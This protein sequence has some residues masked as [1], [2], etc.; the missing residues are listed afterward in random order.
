MRA[1]PARPAIACV[2][3]SVALMPVGETK[4]LGY[5]N[6]TRCLVDASGTA[7][8][9]LRS[10]REREY[11]ICL[12]RVPGPWR[13]GMTAA[14]TW[15]E[16]RDS[17]QFSGVAQR[18]PAIAAAPDGSIHMVWYGGITGATDHQVHYARFTTQGTVR[19][20][21][22]RMPFR[23]PGFESVALNAPSPIELWQEHA[24]IAV[25]PD[26]TAH[27]AWEARDPFRR[28]PDGMPRPGIAYATR[29][30]GGA[31]SVNGVLDR[32][33]Y[34]QINDRFA[35]QSRPSILVDG[36]GTVHVLCY[37]ATGGVQQ[38]LH[39]TIVGREFSGW[40]PVASSSG[41]QRHAAAALDAQGRLH[42]AWREG[43]S[44]GAGSSTM[45]ILYSVRET[46]GRWERPTRLSAPDENASTPSVGVTDSTVS[47]AWVA[48]T[49]GTANS[50]G[51]VDNGFPAD[52]ST[53][54][55]RLEAASS[56]I[57]PTHFEASSVIDP[58]PA[59][60]PCW[61]LGPSRGA[62]RQ[63]LVWSSVDAAANGPRRV[64]LKFGWCEPGR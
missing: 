18:V 3:R 5:A 48:W 43:V 49:P 35:S 55:G 39:G 52:N 23:V 54:E 40:K 42:V 19:I 29:S 26:G 58:G 14:Q 13:V 2:F 9:A 45:A 21:D 8:I 51:Q 44:S 20:D 31:W 1:T 33:P 47:V 64:N 59:S 53:V 50:D 32:P 28:T 7:W 12:L 27:V 57:A 22:E 4:A 36:A 24:A 60:Y 16:D 56:P 15:I 37:G 34:L 25:G 61:A 6:T 38:I 17:L 63:A 10:K 46:D 30:P 11:S 41:D 62:P